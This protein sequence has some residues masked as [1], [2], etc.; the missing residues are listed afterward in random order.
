MS[1]ELGAAADAEP[2]GSFARLI[3]RSRRAT[4]EAT[5]AWLKAERSEGIG[6]EG[7]GTEGAGAESPSSSY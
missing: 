5:I 3:Y 7:A 1:D 4:A 6:A 2:P